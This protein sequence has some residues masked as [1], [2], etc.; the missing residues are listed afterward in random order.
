MLHTIENEFLRITAS[1]QGAELQSIRDREGLEYLWQGDPAYWEKRAINIFPYVARLTG[2]CYYIDGEKRRMD[3]HGLAPYARFRPISNDGTT[4]ILEMTNTLK[5][6]LQYP[7][8]FVFRVIYALKENVLEITYE[9]ENRDEKVMYFG[10]GGHPGFTVPLVPGKKFED[11]RIRFTQPCHPRRVGFNEDCFVTG[12][13]EAFELA[14]GQILPLQHSLF[15]EDAIVL[16]QMTRQVTLETEGDPHSVTVTFPQMDYLGLWHWPQTD[17]PYLCIEPWCSLPARAG[18]ITV[19][20]E[21]RDLIR[22]EAGGIYR[23]TWTVAVN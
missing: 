9:V 6:K 20:E 23:N 4:M 8:R 3:I 18:E 22:L 11:Y 10:L 7:R 5:T 2:G 14:D 17:A 1:E 21:Q 13:Y 12:E 19:F 16:D 15:D